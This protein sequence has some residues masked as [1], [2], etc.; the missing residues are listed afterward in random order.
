LKSLKNYIIDYS[1]K[2][3]P[4]VTGWGVPGVPW[5]PQILADQL[6][7]FQPGGSDYAR[8]INTG[9]PGFSDFS[10]ALKYSNIVLIQGKCILV[11][12]SAHIACF[13]YTI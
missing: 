1:Y 5:H 13:E 7:L 12:K 11:V 6:T 9:T 3:R 2:Y 4:D 8:R 10:T